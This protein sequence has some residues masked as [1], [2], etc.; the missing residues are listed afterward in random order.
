MA[1]QHA[2]LFFLCLFTAYLNAPAPTTGPVA[3]TD[4]DEARL[5][6]MLA[7]DFVEQEGM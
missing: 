5:G 7:D 6:Q 4:A 1:A 2:K 3:L